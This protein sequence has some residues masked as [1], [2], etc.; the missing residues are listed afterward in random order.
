M[1]KL[2]GLVNKLPLEVKITSVDILEKVDS[3][4]ENYSIDS[5]KVASN[6][7]DQNILVAGWLLLK[8]GEVVRSIAISGEGELLKRA[9]VN[10]PRPDVYEALEVSDRKSDQ[11]GFHFE[12]GTFGLKS[13][14]ALDVQ[15]NISDGTDSGQRVID[16]CRIKGRK[17]S[18]LG[19]VTKYQPVQVT[20]IGRSG[21]TLLMQILTQHPE[22]ITTSFYPYEVRVAVYWLKFLKN[23]VAPAD[24][25]YSAH[26][27]KFE[28]ERFKVGANPYSH[29]EYV[30]Q[31]KNP[32]NIKQYHSAGTYSEL[33]R[34]SLER[35]DSYY[36]MIADQENKPRAK[37]FAEKFVPG[38]LQ[39]ICL[40]LYD[41][42]KEIILTRDFRDMLCSAKS[43][44]SKRGN[45]S[46]GRDKVENDLE[47]VDR[48][49][50][51]GARRLCDS[52]D[53]R[54]DRSLHVRYEDLIVR[55]EVEIKRIF[56]Y[57]EIDASSDSVESIVS[58]IFS[59]ESNMAVHSTSSSP[60]TSVG[61]WKTDMPKELRDH[62]K[63]KLGYALE[64]FGYE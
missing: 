45:Q 29:P 25:E 11:I 13:D 18:R 15:A 59:K 58:R 38:P 22:I 16:L 32:T 49:S 46:F 10:V 33:A 42:S 3:V 9:Q 63:A 8:E 12:V 37:F 54:G 23:M 20:A 55:P 36:S 47:W 1:A 28:A 34:L 62:C 4:V 40:D 7:Q 56:E 50:K 48:L 17:V 44:N 43:F 51:L 60:K 39:N 53:Q 24:F 57:L 26:P 6:S 41:N 64:A 14:F 27:D 31:Y 61:R 52:L 19:C 5:P 35:I 30:N 2:T 21:T